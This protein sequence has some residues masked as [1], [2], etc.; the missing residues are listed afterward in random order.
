MRVGNRATRGRV[1]KIASARGC[2]RG[3]MVQCDFAHPTVAHGGGERVDR[4]VAAGERAAL[5]AVEARE[6][7]ERAAA[8]RRIGVHG[9]GSTIWRTLASTSSSDQS[10]SPTKCSSD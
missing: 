9:G 8:V 7:G 4:G 6:L 2:P 10:D 3:L 1:G 5:V